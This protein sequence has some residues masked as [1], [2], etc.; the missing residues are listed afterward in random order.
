MLHSCPAARREAAAAAN[1]V[2]IACFSS[3]VVAGAF[4]FTCVPCLHEQVAFYAFLGIPKGNASHNATLV[5]VA[6]WRSQSA[7]NYYTTPSLSEPPPVLRKRGGGRRARCSVRRLNDGEHVPRGGG[8]G[9]P[10]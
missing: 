9:A 8:G 6:A 1:A 5:R 3:S 7:H 4:P 2:V 10:R